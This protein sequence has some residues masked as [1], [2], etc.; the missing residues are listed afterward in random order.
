MWVFLIL[1]ILMCACCHI[2]LVSFCI[3]LMTDDAEYPFI[4]LFAITTIFSCKMSFQIFYS[5]LK[6][7]LFV[8]LLTSCKRSLY[9]LDTK[10]L[11]DICFANRCSQTVAYLLIFAMYFK[12]QEFLIVMKFDLPVFSLWFM[13]FGPV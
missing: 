4:C 1:A 13:V 10:P 12:D 5:F 2:C 6:I 7:R 3:S 8:Y 9:I 11:W